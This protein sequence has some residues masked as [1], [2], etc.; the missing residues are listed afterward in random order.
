MKKY[1]LLVL[2][3][4]LSKA[5]FSQY[6]STLLYLRFPIVP[7]FKLTNVEDSSTFTKDNLKKKKWTIIMMFSPDCEHCQAVT[8]ELTAN[9]KLFKKAQIVMASPLNYD[10]I[11]KFYDEYK[12]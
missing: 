6:D 5:G 12:I 2:I 3:V 11:R 1:L 7:S 8:K 4:A 9:I 10:Y